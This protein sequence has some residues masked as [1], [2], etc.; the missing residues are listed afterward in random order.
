MGC[1]RGM[2]LSHAASV[3]NSKGLVGIYQLSS[4]WCCLSR[5][6]VERGVLAVQHGLNKDNHVSSGRGGDDA[7]DV[8]SRERIE[9]KK[10]KKKATTKKHESRSGDVNT[11]T[12]P[13]SRQGM[14][15]HHLVELGE[16]DEEFL[17]QQPV[18]TLNW[19]IRILGKYKRPDVAEQ[20]F[21]WMRLKAM[22]N[23]HSLLKLFE[24]LEAARC[25]PARAVRAWRNVSRMQCPFTPGC[26]ST[27]GLLKTFRPSKDLKGA[28]RILKEVKM[29]G[30]PLNEYGYN[31]VIRIAADCGDVET[32]LALEEELRLDGNL[33]V[34]VRTYS[35][36]MHA[37]ASTQKWS[38]TRTV[39]G[40]LRRVDLRPDATLAL[41]LISG[42]ARCGWPAAAE[43]ILD[44]FSENSGRDRPNRS[45][46]NALLYA[47]ATARQ[48]NGCLMAYKRM[49]QEVGIRPDSYTMVALLKAGRRSQAGRTAVSFVL[50]QV[51]EHDVAI[52]VELASSAIACCRTVP[53]VSKDEAVKSRDLA[54]SVWDL[55][56]DTGV[57]PNRI[58]YNTLMAARSDAGDLNGVKELFDSLEKNP[59]VYPDEATWN[60]LLKTYERE[61]DWKALES[62]AV[63]RD[64]WRTLH[65]P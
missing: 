13:V 32:A 38:Q 52:T 17:E 1:C 20:L 47:Y 16:F 50:H 6:R 34:D 21:H 64:T 33:Q 59:H 18:N 23:E 24:G 7:R 19:C 36:L 11:V 51:Q 63:L 10:K 48:Y 5:R 28:L 62:T 61:G 8:A 15:V 40:L 39:D 12:V 46:W 27:A 44:E 56:I 53:Y 57:E 9:H 26:L 54:D 30:L 41:Q 14:I 58:A 42:Y 31:I 4:L 65:D 2:P 22:A 25:P 49:T 55:M 3:P 60:I 45:H 35:A 37:L 29:R 43:A